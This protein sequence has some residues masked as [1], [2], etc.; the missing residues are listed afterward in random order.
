MLNETSIPCRVGSKDYVAKFKPPRMVELSTGNRK[1]GNG[2]VI[3]PN[4][5]MC[6]NGIQGKALTINIC[7]TFLFQL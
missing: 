5:C 6:P 3:S 7:T 1:K 4:S 2:R